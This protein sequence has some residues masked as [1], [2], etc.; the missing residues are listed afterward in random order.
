M[1]WRQIGNVLDRPGQLDLPAGTRPSGGICAPT[2]R[3][4]DSRFYV[5]TTNVDGGGNFLVSSE[6]PQG[7]WC[8]PVWID[9]S[10]IDPDLARDD[11]GTC[12]V[13][14]AGVGLA[15]I[16]RGAGKALEGPVPVWS[17][18]GMRHPEAPHLHRIGDWR[19]LPL[20]GGGTAHGHSVSI[21]RARSPRGPCE[22]APANPIPS[23]RSTDL[24]IQC[25]GHA[26][27][28]RAPDGT[29]WML[30][31]AT[32]PRGCFPSFHVLGR[33]TFLAPV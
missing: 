26:D 7:P 18:A 16:D 29:W 4:H 25:T 12:W 19:Y 30:R 9:L 1:R 32:R 20:A 17:G 23:H 6:Q 14:L 24:P 13:A 21:D 8:D 10:G 5:I 33:E 3:H 31:P 28:V 15:R 2:I 11:D 27:L 22:P